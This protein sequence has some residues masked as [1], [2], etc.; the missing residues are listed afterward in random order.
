M[1]IEVPGCIST[2]GH[3]LQAFN[4]A[5]LRERLQRLRIHNPEAI[6][7]S[8]INSF[9]NP[10]HEL[11]ARDIIR[12]E[13]PDIPM[14]ISYEVLPELMEYERTITTVADAYIKLQLDKYL[15]RLQHH[16]GDDVTLRVL[17]SDGGLSTADLACANPVNMLMSGPSGGVAGV[18]SL[19]AKRTESV[20]LYFT[21]QHTL[22]EDYLT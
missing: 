14:S 10:S 15:R 21:C 18:I 11:L 2:Q 17:R 1:T 8:L 12:Q 20:S 13:F 7:I 5:V 19:V 9:S 22:Q 3:E 16:L 4:E 6:T